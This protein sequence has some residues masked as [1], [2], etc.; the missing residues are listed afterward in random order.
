[1]GADSL[2]AEEALSRLLAEHLGDA[3]DDAVTTVRGEETTWSRVLESACTGSLFAPQRAVVVRNAEQT[4][5]EDE[6][7]AGY[8][9]QPAPGVLAKASPK[10]AT[11]TP[12][13][14]NLVERSAPVNVSSPPRRRSATTRAIS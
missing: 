2:L 8:L 12:I 10:L 3:R 13:S 1:M 9:D 6:G 5:G 11:S 7:V 14:F 4:K